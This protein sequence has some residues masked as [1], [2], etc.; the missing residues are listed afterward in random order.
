MDLVVAKLMLVK[1]S[2]SLMHR[3]PSPNK[4]CMQQSAVTMGERRGMITKFNP[5]E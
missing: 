1:L 3:S 4:E 5:K 2:C